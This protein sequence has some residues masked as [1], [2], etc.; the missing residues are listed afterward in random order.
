M[1]RTVIKILKKHLGDAYN[2]EEA[3]NYNNQWEGVIRSPY[4]VLA[5]SPDTAE[6]RRLACELIGV[7][8]GTDFAKL[9]HIPTQAEA[10]AWVKANMFDDDENDD[11]FISQTA[12]Q[13]RLWLYGFRTQIIGDGD[14]MGRRIV[15]RT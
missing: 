14:H 13:M 8:K 10:E 4:D 9:I 11:E 3:L 2:E 15:P 7:I 5:D 6:I 12:R 1:I